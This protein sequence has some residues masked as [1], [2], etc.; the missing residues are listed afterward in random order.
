MKRIGLTQRVEVVEAYGERRDCL[1]QQWARLLESMPAVPVPL[2]NVTS[3]PDSLIDT[4]GLDG[5]ILTG[6]NNLSTI[7]SVGA[8]PE[9]DVFERR[10][11]EG[12]LRKNTPVLGV[13]RGMQLLNCH[14][15][16][17]LVPIDGHV[18]LRHCVE[19]DGYQELWPNS[20]INVN[21][22]HDYGVSDE[23]LAESLEAVGFSSDGSVE[24]LRHRS[25]NIWGIMWHPEREA[26]FAAPD[27]KLLRAIFQ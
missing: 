23:I 22:Y 17:S 3:V 5:V 27:L 14:F 9:R 18:A 8:A 2:P 10:L 12:C 21:S 16:G 1:D 20:R 15:G 26:P 19:I 24:A 25:R 13:C 7:S 11:V 6:G 4:L